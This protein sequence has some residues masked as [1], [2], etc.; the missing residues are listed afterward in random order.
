MAL[1]RGAARRVA[2][3]AARRRGSIVEARDVAD[4]PDILETVRAA[5]SAGR[6]GAD[7]DGEGGDERRPRQ[8]VPRGG[9]GRAS[10]TS[11]VDVAAAAPAGDRLRPR[12][13][14]H[15][16]AR[17]TPACSDRQTARSR[18]RCCVGL[19]DLDRICGARG[20]VSAPA[21]RHARAAP[22]RGAGESRR[23][24]PRSSRVEHAVPASVAPLAAT[25]SVVRRSSLRSAR[26]CATAR[27]APIGSRSLRDARSDDRSARAR[28]R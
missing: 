26:R 4:E 28:S 9:R 17:T 27:H 2:R 6:R 14:H 19:E 11:R 23:R 20:R 21:A 25:D 5:R 24:S 13:A 18:A 22:R 15:R 12:G 8:A 16:P 7:G 1:V 3:D 10:S